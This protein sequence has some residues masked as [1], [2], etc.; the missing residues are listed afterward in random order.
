[1]LL[2][3]P[4]LGLSPLLVQEIF[5]I[6]KHHFPD[7]DVH[8]STQLNTHNEGQILFL[9]QLTASRV[10]LSREL[11]FFDG[12]TINTGDAKMDSLLSGGGMSGMLTTTWLIMTALSIICFGFFNKLRDNAST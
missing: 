2:D 7:L 4:S 6:L 9:N 10:N 3:E 8:A 11:T 12:F 1:M 5:A